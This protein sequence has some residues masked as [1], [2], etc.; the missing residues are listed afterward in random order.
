M[1]THT[2]IGYN[3][4]KE[5]KKNLEDEGLYDIALEIVRHHHERWDGNGYPDSI[6]KEEIP[7][8]ARIMSI[9]DVY[10]A[11]LSERPI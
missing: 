11:L 2:I 9:V 6:S 1:K 5:A 3:I 4:I 7:L 10:D 8:S